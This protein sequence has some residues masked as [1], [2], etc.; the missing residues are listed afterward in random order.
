MKAV[1]NNIL[2]R[3]AKEETISKTEG[4]LLLTGKQKQD[5]RYKQAT[6]INFGDLVQGLKEVTRFI[7]IC[8]L[9]I[10]SK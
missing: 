3:K 1:G 6:V 10:E 7:T 5:L 8:T 2:I 4:G 9:D